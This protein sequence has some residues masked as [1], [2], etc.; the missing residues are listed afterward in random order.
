MIILKKLNNLRYLNRSIIFFIDLIISA[1]S[2]SVAYFLVAF[3]A[4]YKINNDILFYYFIFSA[5]ISILLFFFTGLFKNVIRHSSI[6]ELPRIF[7]IMFVKAICLMIIVFA[8]GYLSPKF[9]I[10]CALL[11]MII[12]SFVMISWRALL[13]NIYYTLIDNNK[14]IEGNAF[15][16]GANGLSS[17]I[18][19]DMS[20]DSDFKY[21]IK[22]CLSKSKKEFGIKIGG[23]RVYEISDDKVILAKLFSKLSIDYLLFSSKEDFNKER[24]D[25][26]EFCIS[27]HIK[28]L[29]LGDFKN[30]GTNNILNDVKQI[31]VEDL[32][33]RDVINTEIDRISSLMDGKTV[34][35][36]GAAG[37]IGSEV[38]RQLVK[39][40]ISKLILFDNAET[41]LHNLNLELDRMCLDK[42]IVYF[43]G[44]VR[45]KDRVKGVFNRFDIDFVFHA[46]AYKHVPMIENNP[47][48]SILANVWGT[49]N[50]AHYSAK[51]KVDKFIMISTDKAVNPTS[52]MGASK[53]IAEM[54][55]QTL[56]KNTCTTQFIVTRFGNVL[57]SNGSVIPF[58]KKQI[59]NGGPVSVTHKDMVRYFMTIPE[60]CRLV[61]QASAMGKGG[62]IYL[63]DMG[64]QVNISDLANRMISLSG[65]VPNQDIKIEYVGLRPGEKLYEEMLTS[66][67]TTDATSHE[68]IRVSHIQEFD[69]PQHNLSV[70]KLIVAARRNDIAST[71]VLMKHI[72]PE[73]ISNNSQFQI[74]DNKN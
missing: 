47:C 58:F 65:F 55:V 12:S 50:V 7:V 52:V 69:I 49:I 42:E 38:V 14:H 16:Y 17:M 37:S 13:I 61:L 46:A 3:I 56:D 23:K 29:V 54:C 63:F 68:K 25:L 4:G 72:L 19:K 34:L 51:N 30:Q 41:P 45:S 48:E 18:I 39:L 67:E 2:T 57:G 33:Q 15:I 21:N 74:Y 73:Y 20:C 24:L 6:R 27:N 40:N 31:D 28:M 71:I 36:T 66:E 5:L 26:V 22:G 59:E 9:I 62:E 32:L 11:D 70:R 60:A 10:I 53:R 44:D 8:L 1:F 43:L 64:E 35:V